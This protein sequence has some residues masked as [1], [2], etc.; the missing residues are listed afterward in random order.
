[1]RHEKLKDTIQSVAPRPIHPNAVIARRPDGST[2]QWF[3]HFRGSDSRK[4]ERLRNRIQAKMKRP[5][6]A[7]KW[8]PFK[9]RYEMVNIGPRKSMTE[10]ERNRIE[11]A[12]T[13]VFHEHNPHII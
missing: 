5:R 12:S 6:A 10:R 11:R 2:F 9:G 3:P 7:A 1:M 4:S 8:D 13:Y